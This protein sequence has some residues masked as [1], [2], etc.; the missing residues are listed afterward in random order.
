MTEQSDLAVRKEREENL[1]TSGVAGF[2]PNLMLT[3]PNSEVATKKVCE[4]G[5]FCYNQELDVG[6]KVKLIILAKRFHAVLIKNGSK[7]H[8][9]FNSSSP[10]TDDITSAVRDVPKLDPRYG[11][12]WLCFL[13][14]HNVF[15][16][17][18]PNTPSSRPI[19]KV[20]LNHMRKPEERDSDVAKQ[21]IYTNFFTLSSIVREKP[22]TH[23]VPVAVSIKPV[24]EDMPSDELIKKHAL[25]FFK[26]VEQEPQR[27]KVSDAGDSER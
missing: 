1:A 24:P 6:E 16:V 4:P 18:H 11:Y 3:H 14:E 17:F 26:P 23:F 13:P 25:V 15:A 27:E 20:F 22:Q 9:T 19:S 10:I 21:Q 7:V 8:E 5:H 2:V 12:S